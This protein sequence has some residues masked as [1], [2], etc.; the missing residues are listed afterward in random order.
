[1]ALHF[2]Q[3]LNLGLGSSKQLELVVCGFSAN[4]KERM[5]CGSGPNVGRG[6]GGH[7][8][9]G[10]GIETAVLGLSLCSTTCLLCASL[11]E[12][13]GFSSGVSVLPA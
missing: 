2:P 10:A 1:M 8:T 4:A 5:D 3:P 13:G 7:T 9:R 11:A 6:W 12:Q